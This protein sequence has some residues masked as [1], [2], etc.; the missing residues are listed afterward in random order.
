LDEM[1]LSLNGERLVLDQSGALFWPSQET[2]VVAD[3]HFEKG[4]AYARSGSLLPPYDTR[5]TLARLSSAVGRRRPNRVIALGDSFHDSGAG[6]R[7]GDIERQIL[8]HLSDVAR[9]TWITG[10]HDPEPPAWLSGEIAAEARI[11]GLVFRH[12]PSRVFDMGEVAGHLHPCATV[13]RRGHGLRR[14]CFVSDGMRLVL[15]AFGA[16]AGGLDVRDAAIAGLF[17][18]SSIAYLLGARRVYAAPVD[19]R[20]AELFSNL[21]P[22]AL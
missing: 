3:L 12:E 4:S 18:R 10:N 15:P 20:S 5:E 22:T 13:V 2:L 16:Y 7:L 19:R 14:R 9:F 17:A 6:A 21:L 8:E 11:G 1:C